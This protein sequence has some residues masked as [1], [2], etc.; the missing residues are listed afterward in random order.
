[1]LEQ[2][3]GLRALPRQALSGRPGHEV[4]LPPAAPRNVASPRRVERGAGLP[5][6]PPGRPYEG[7]QGSLQR[8]YAT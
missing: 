7:L 2:G 8:A 1:V 5:E 4:P 6:T 3:A